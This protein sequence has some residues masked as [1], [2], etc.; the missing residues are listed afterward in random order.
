MFD[1]AKPSFKQMNGKVQIPNY[2]VMIEIKKLKVMLNAELS[3]DIIVKVKKVESH[4][5]RPS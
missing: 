5:F 4:E 3:L 1:L 2:Y